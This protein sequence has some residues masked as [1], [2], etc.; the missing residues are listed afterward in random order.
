MEG[1]TYNSDDQHTQ[2]QDDDDIL[3]HYFN[4][5]MKQSPEAKKMYISQLEK[6]IHPEVLKLE[7]PFSDRKNVS[8]DGNCGYRS[9]AHQIY[10]SED[11]LRRVRNDLYDFLEGRLD[12]W[13]KK[14]QP[15]CFGRYGG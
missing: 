10:G 3:W 1:A 5:V 9:V 8:A 7:E 12:Y 6:L 4:I 14:V 15:F 2:F 11:Q 13:M